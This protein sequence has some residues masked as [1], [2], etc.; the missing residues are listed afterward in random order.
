MK[1]VGVVLTV[2]VTGII[3]AACS[4]SQKVYNEAVNYINNGQY[5]EAIVKIKE[6]EGTENSSDK[7]AEAYNLIIETCIRNNDLD[8][9]MNA[10]E[11]YR[12]SG[13]SGSVDQETYN[14]AQAYLDAGNYENSFSLLSGLGSSLNSDA[15]LTEKVSELYHKDIIT[16]ELAA[17]YI[18]PYDLL[19][20]KDK[21]FVDFCTK[22]PYSI[23]I[24]VNETRE[25]DSYAGFYNGLD[26]EYK[27]EITGVLRS[28]LKKLSPTKDYD[29]YIIWLKN[30]KEDTTRAS[31]YHI[32]SGKITSSYEHN[33]APDVTI[34]SC[35]SPDDSFDIEMINM[36]L[37]DWKAAETKQP[38]ADA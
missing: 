7:V 13:V 2:L 1:R 28:D 38:N 18:N 29:G 17:T 14:I 11:Q 35:Y 31:F 21:E 23:N 10:L 24:S 26:E 19:N 36:A 3:I 30:I 34:E 25:Y 22:N 27:Y 8:S 20:D 16:A 12:S 33:Y 9:A 15:F 32:E 6:L 5:Q 4:A 37:F